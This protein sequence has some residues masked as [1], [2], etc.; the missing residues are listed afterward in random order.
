MQDLHGHIITYQVVL[1]AQ[2]GKKVFTL[3]TLLEQ[4][5][6]DSGSQVSS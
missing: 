4:V 2:R 1:G 5:D 6:D 3:K